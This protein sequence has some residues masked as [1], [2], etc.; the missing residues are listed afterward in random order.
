MKKSIL[1]FLSTAVFALTSLAQSHLSIYCTDSTLYQTRLSDGAQITHDFDASGELKATFHDWVMGDVALRP[2]EI[3]RMK[4]SSSEIPVLHL[5]FPSYP[6]AETVWSKEDYVD[7]TLRVEGN[8]MVPDCDGLSLQVRGR[9]N[10]TWTLPKKPMRLKFSKKT[11]IC[12]FPKM[13]NYVLLANFIDP[14]LM[15]NAVAMWLAEKLDVP[16]ANTM[17]P[18][19]VVINGHYA[20]AYTLTEKIGI[21]S[22]SVDI[23][24][25]LGILFELSSEYDEKYKFRSAFNGHPVMVK[26]PDFDELYAENPDGL[27]PQERLALWEED[28]N[29]AEALGETARGSESFDLESTVNY[30]LLYSI[31]NNSEIGFPKSLYLHKRALGEDEKYFL[32]PAWDFD[33]AF[34]LVAPDKTTGELKMT[35]PTLKTWFPG[36]IRGMWDDPAFQAL[37]EKRIKWVQEDLLPQLLEFIDSYAATIEPSAKLNARRWPDD[38][39]NPNWLYAYS[40]AD[41]SHHVATMRQWLI[42]RINF[43]VSSFEI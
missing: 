3:N 7:A 30:V 29:R 14:T 40:S 26:D 42:D 11:S 34:N 32:G 19:H 23:D 20:G 43:L 8:A 4:V 15:R 22:T 2:S 21:N 9:G 28:F 41:H 36:F 24:E 17:L 16:F 12:G 35:D 27:S 18:C 13:K 25:N 5:S 39:F 1:S 37:Y 38:Y 31:V 33:V 6:E 10:S